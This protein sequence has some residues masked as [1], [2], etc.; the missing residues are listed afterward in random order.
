MKGT[1]FAIFDPAE[2]KE[3]EK[4]DKRI[5]AMKEKL[6]MIKKNDTCELVNKPQNKKSIGVKWAYR[7]KL[8][9][10]GSINKYNSTLVVKGS[11]QVFE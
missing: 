10:D 1:I 8:N 5:E 4:D 11:A 6:K 2:F 7:T 9:A 3:A